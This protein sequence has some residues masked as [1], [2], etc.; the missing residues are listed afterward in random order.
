MS[1]LP[2]LVLLLLLLCSCGDASGGGGAAVPSM[3]VFQSIIYISFDEPGTVVVR[4]NSISFLGCC[5]LSR[6]TAVLAISPNR[7]YR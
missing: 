1:L 5:K 2:L 6:R 7:L 4:P 3:R